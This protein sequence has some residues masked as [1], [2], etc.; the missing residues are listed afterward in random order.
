MTATIDTKTAIPADLD[1][2]VMT[3]IVE[4]GYGVGAWHG[5]DMNAALTDVTA[6]TA[7]WRPAG[8]R[9][10]IAE[11]AL[12]HAYYVRSVRAQISGTTPDAFVL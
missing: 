5:P 7:F 9:H 6:A 4:E 10:N 11:I 2:R 1:P 3:R 12:H 8:D